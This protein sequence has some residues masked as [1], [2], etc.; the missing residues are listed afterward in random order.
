MCWRPVFIFWA[1]PR[2]RRCN[3]CGGIGNAA[4]IDALNRARERPGYAVQH[5][6]EEFDLTGTL[7]TV[8]IS[9][10]DP[11]RGTVQVNTSQIDLTDGTWSG[12][13]FTDYPITITARANA[14]YEFAG[15]KGGADEMADTMTLP[16]DGGLTLEAVFVER[17]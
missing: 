17:K 7:E 11:S 15:W 8:T 16:V 10:A 13:Y 4:S 9:T 1:S 12:Q 5:L 6:A 3:R 14:E 2:R